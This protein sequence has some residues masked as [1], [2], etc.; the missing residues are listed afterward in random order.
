M[1]VLEKSFARLSR[2]MSIT[3]ILVLGSVFPGHPDGHVDFQGSAKESFLEGALASCRVQEGGLAISRVGLSNCDLQATLQVRYLNQWPA[4]SANLHPFKIF[5]FTFHKCQDPIQAHSR[6]SRTQCL[7][8]TVVRVVV[9]EGSGA[10]PSR[11][12]HR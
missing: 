1:L 6:C 7:E 5:A 2:A 3:F 8:S 9:V 12:E 10:L 11:A 4:G